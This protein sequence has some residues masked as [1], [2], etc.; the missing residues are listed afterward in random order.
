M[1]KKLKR[2]TTHPL[3]VGPEGLAAALDC[4]RNTADRIGKAAGAKVKIGGCARYSVEKVK[5]YLDKLAEEQ[6]A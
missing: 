6:G 1:K 3:F 5:A 4:G 2:E